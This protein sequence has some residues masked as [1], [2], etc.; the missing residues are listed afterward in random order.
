[1]ITKRRARR[2]EFV[3]MVKNQGLSVTDIYPAWIWGA[4]WYGAG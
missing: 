4:E 1:M 3:R 2:V